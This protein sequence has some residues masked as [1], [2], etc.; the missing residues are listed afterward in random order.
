MSL[1]YL[2]YFEIVLCNVIVLYNVI[3]KFCFFFLLYYVLYYNL[4][5]KFITINVKKRIYKA[6]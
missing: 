5:N 6:K 4:Y 3:C 2:R 1:L